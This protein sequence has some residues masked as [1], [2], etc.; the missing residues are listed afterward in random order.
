MVKKGGSPTPLS[1]K[2]AFRSRRWPRKD[3]KNQFFTENR[4]TG[5][6]G[7]LPE[8]HGFAEKPPQRGG[9]GC[10]APETFG[11]F[12]FGWGFG[13][14]FPNLPQSAR[15]SR[16]H[17]EDPCPSPKRKPKKPKRTAPFPRCCPF[18]CEKNQL[19]TR[20]GNTRNRYSSDS[21]GAMTQGLMES[22]MFRRQFSSSTFFSTSA[23]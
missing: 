7:H 20:M 22:F 9:A 2:R 12:H 16:C 15:K 18:A 1:G 3:C 13:Y 23:M 10:P 19:A 8:Y 21:Q 17:P 6:K 4:K 14:A 11:F 5:K